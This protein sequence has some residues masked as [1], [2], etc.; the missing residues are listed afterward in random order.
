MSATIFCD[1]KRRPWIIFQS[2]VPHRKKTGFRE[3][4][5]RIFLLNVVK[6]NRVLFRITRPRTHGLF[7]VGID[8]VSALDCWVLM[9]QVSRG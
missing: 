9:N 4:A 7:G 6:L 1:S 5:T 8:G 2:S 3:S